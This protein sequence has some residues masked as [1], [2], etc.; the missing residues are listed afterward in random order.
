MTMMMM[1]TVRP[2]CVLGGL[3]NRM[4]TSLAPAVYKQGHVLLLL[5]G[6]GRKPAEGWY[7]AGRAGREQRGVVRVRRVTRETR[8]GLLFQPTQSPC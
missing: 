2:E 4:L 3:C 5:K 1:P 8:A 6:D 7:L